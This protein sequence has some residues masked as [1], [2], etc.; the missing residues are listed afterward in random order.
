MHHTIQVCH[1][2][3]DMLSGLYC[4]PV[5]SAVEGTLELARLQLSADCDQSEYG[6]EF[7]SNTNSTSNLNS[8][9]D[10]SADAS[11]NRNSEEN[12][13]GIGEG[14]KKKRLDLFRL[15]PVHDEFEF[16]NKL[17]AVEVAGQKASSD[18]CHNFLTQ[19][20]VR[21]LHTG[22]CMLDPW[23]SRH[24]SPA[25]ASSSNPKESAVL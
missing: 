9:E 18:A 2:Q 11:A 22:T 19:T 13:H 3:L 14:P 15:G 10:A 6:I 25:P 4:S 5:D 17:F 23:R 7:L 8:N 12:V 21:C 20:G 24:P 1:L 16:E